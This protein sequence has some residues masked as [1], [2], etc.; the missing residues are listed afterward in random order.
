M[1]NVVTDTKYLILVAIVSLLT[2]NSC[3]GSGD[4]AKAKALLDSATEA[5]QEGNYTKAIELTDSLR[6]AYPSE[7]EIRREAL[8]LSTRATERL[9]LRRLE[10]ADSLLAVLSVRGDSLSRLVRFVEN[11]IEGYY[12]A[13]NVKDGNVIG[14]N[15][16]QARLSPAGDFY[17]ISSLKA[18]QVKSTSV[19]VECD[20]ESATTSTIPHDGERND[21]SMG[22]E[23]ITYMASECDTV[24]AFISKHNSRPITLTFNGASVYKMPLPK[25]EAQ[26]ITTLYDYA[27]TLRRAKLASLEKEKLTRAIDISRAQAAKTFVEKTE[28]EE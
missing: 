1:F 4:K 25:V 3:S 7:I 9:A 12:V 2:L 20:G 11:P 14:S 24:A 22:A 13:G 17:M 10:T 15:G 21:R 26:N 5:F 27:I 16:L 6:S 28:D 19:T 8:H 18:K 23:I